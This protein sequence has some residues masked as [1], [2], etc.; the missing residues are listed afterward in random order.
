MKR[1]PKNW[2][3]LFHNSFLSKSFDMY[4]DRIYTQLNIHTAKSFII[5]LEILFLFCSLTL[6]K[7]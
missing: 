5:N 6:L 4:T 3:K 2:D 1:K 7:A